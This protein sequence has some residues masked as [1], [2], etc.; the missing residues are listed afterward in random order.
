MFSFLKKGGA[1]GPAEIG[2]VIDPRQDAAFI[3]EAPRKLFRPEHKSNHAKSLSACPAMKDFESRL[4]EITSPIDIHLRFTRDQNG[5]PTMVAIDGERSTVRPQYLSKLLM[6]VHPS[7]WRHPSRPVLQIMTPYLFVADEPVYI[8]VMPPFFHYAAKALPG[9]VVGGRFPI[10]VWPR[11]LVWAFEWHDISREIQI[12][13]GDPWFY[14]AFETC[15]P[16]RTTR[17]VE[18]EMTQALREYTN[19]IAGVTNYVGQTYS[20]F[21]TARQRRP[22]KLLSP[23]QHRK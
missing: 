11:S 6:P 8:S 14:V 13:R 9:I 5:E 19:G 22:A 2:W 4:I 15:D 10:D 20:L 3:W 21:G 12:N 18:A 23:K 17:L 1:T 7:E 16:S